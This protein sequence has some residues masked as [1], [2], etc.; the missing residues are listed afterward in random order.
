MKLP[1]LIAVFALTMAAV[2]SAVKPKESKKD[3]EPPPAVE[4]TKPVPLL[5]LGENVGI[6]SV[7]W[8]VETNYS[9]L[10][11]LPT[12]TVDIGK[13]VGNG[14]QAVVVSS[15][16]YSTIISGKETNTF[17]TQ[18][19]PIEITNRTFRQLVVRI[20]QDGSTEVV[21]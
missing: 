3:A 12:G 14:T 1:T 2:F 11:S 7:V 9:K 5:S 19:I 6:Q 17:R 21:Q 16:Q 4:P 13:I 8:K 20:F 10:P 18:S 15:N